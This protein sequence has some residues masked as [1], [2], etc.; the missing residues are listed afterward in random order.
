[1][2]GK[3]TASI[4]SKLAG[5]LNFARSL[6]SGRPLQAPLWTFSQRAAGNRCHEPLG[7]DE[8]I[9]FQTTRKYTLV[10]TPKFIPFTPSEVSAILYTDGAVEDGK[11]TYGAV[12]CIKGSKVRVTQEMVPREQ[13]A[14]WLEL[15]SRHCVAQTEL[16]PVLKSKQT[17][18]SYLT[19]ADLVHYTDNEAVRGALIKG[20]TSS[21]ASRDLLQK[22]LECELEL[23]GRTW[24]TRVPSESNP[25][26]L[27]SRGRWEDLLDVL[28]CVRDRVCDRRGIGRR[29]TTCGSAVPIVRKNGDGA[30]KRLDR[31]CH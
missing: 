8:L 4:A 19:D 12:L 30:S 16:I 27:P 24:V 25:A 15:G 5:R 26:D 18:G 14:E 3:W 17:W 2:E 11:A 10:A 23:N 6:A 31:P 20:T 29:N 9:A 13:V 7:Q 1:M 22:I 21:L 28:D